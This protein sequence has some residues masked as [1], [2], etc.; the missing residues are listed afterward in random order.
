MN[1]HTVGLKISLQIS[2]DL[3]ERIEFPGDFYGDGSDEFSYYG[4]SSKGN[5]WGCCLTLDDG[6][7]AGVST[8]SRSQLTI[9]DNG[10]GWGDASSF[11]EGE[12]YS[13]RYGDGISSG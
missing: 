4:E 10:D 13:T 1:W 2:L 7:G 6:D 3:C 9:F 11:L 5:G 12:T 8:D